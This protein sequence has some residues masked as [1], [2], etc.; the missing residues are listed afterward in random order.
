MTDLWKAVAAATAAG[1]ILNGLRLRRR[2][3]G[4]AVLKP[5]PAPG[6]DLAGPDGDPGGDVG[7]DGGH[8]GYRFVTAT[9]VTLDGPTRAAAIAHARRAGLDVLALVPADAPAEQALDLARLVDTRSYRG[10]RLSAGRGAGHAILASAAVLGQAGVNQRSG[11]HP[12]NFAQTEARLKQY[13][14]A[15]ADLAVA[16]ALHGCVPGPATR[17]A[18]LNALGIPVP[19]AAALPAVRWLAL[20]ATATAR[21]RWGALV[22]G[23]YLA[24][25]YLVFAGLPV[26]PRDLP[27][28]AVVRPLR[29]PFCWIKT[30]TGS[31]P[32][33]ADGR[34]A[35]AEAAAR[36]R[37]DLADGTARFFERRRA[38]CPWCGSGRLAR[39]VTTGDQLQRKPG[40]FT[41]EECSDCGH[42]FQNPRLTPEG[43][44]FYY[45]DCYDGHGST[46]AE[47]AFAGSGTSYRRRA[48][49]VAAVTTPVSWLD[50]GTGGGH[51]CNVARD[52]LPGTA[53]DGL[54]LSSQV[55]EAQRR[56]W[57]GRGYRG[58]FPGLSADLIGRYDVISMCHYLEHTRDPGAELDAA[59]L[60]LPPGG[61]LL[62]E[63][64]DP[65]FRLGRQLGQLWVPWLQP[66]HQHMIPFANLRQALTDRGFT[67]VAAERG[68]AHQATDLAGAAFLMLT[69][70]APDPAVPWSR[71]RVTWRRRARRWAVL[72]A[73]SPLVPAGMVADKVIAPAFRAADQGNAYRLLARKSDR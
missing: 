67:V 24:Q 58:T 72:A 25:P 61:H 60:A 69:A 55:E 54:D 6:W 59:A 50:V 10:D 52:V 34:Q 26:R 47:A 48:Q 44:E 16:P 18:S 31:T 8:A 46:L 20:A 70:L 9:G 4:I 42:V 56:G 12:E 5:Q 36:Y 30:I 1:I 27:A 37:A 39:L 63:V 41:L 73:G 33:P 68:G 38:S 57:V 7:G 65:Q 32:A 14:P 15:T 43:L 53:F 11:L 51:F 3:S 28:Q 45:R 23:A 35:S 21:P 71:Q 17:R 66:Q 62:I 22:A 2:I 19:L 49:M 29:E 13:A 64:P 40:R